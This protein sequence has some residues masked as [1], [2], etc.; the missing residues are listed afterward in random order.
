MKSEVR[1][2]C[3][4]VHSTRAEAAHPSKPRI[5]KVMSTEASGETFSGNRAR[6]VINRNNQ[7]RERNKS[8]RLVARRSQMPPR[9]PANPPTS[10][11]N[12]VEIN[13]AAGA[14]SNLEWGATCRFRRPEQIIVGFGFS[15]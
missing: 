6:T 7:G 8:V 5:R 12:N 14:S 2:D 3:A 9:Y 10:A 1:N 15:S 13:A 11:A 4:L